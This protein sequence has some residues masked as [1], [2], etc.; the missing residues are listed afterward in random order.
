MSVEIYGMTLSAPTRTVFMTCDMLGVTYDL[1]ETNLFEGATTTPEYLKVELISS[2]YHW[3]TY[4]TIFN[5]I[6][7]IFY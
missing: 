3:C 2:C 1:K 5:Y 7:S 6:I 4:L